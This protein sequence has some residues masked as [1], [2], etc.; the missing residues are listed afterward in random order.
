M[1]ELTVR[2][3]FTA[4]CL[5]NVKK[6]YRTKGKLQHYYELPRNPNNKIVFMPTW[7]LSTLRQA[8]SIL[9]KHHKEVEKVRFALEVEGNP[10]P[11]TEV[12]KR[13]WADD[14]FSKHEAFFPGDV[15]SVT[16]AV[17]SAISDDDFIRLM[18]YAGKYCGISPSQPNKFGFYEVESI[19]PTVPKQ[20]VQQRALGDRDEVLKK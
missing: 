9:C 2:L 14:Q 5:G 18:T 6:L 19:R 20:P 12:Y 1:R 17:P 8:A 7:W 3:M 11:L 15:I 16:C 13:Y 4:Y 10:R